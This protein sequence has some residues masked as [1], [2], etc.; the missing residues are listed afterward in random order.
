[1]LE[2]VFAVVGVHVWV[3]GFVGGAGGGV[4]RG[5]GG[6]RGLGVARGIACA[7]GRYCLYCFKF[8]FFF[9]IDIESCRYN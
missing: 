2:L 1:M 3:V 8:G 7:C 9:L 6:W 4:W 5:S